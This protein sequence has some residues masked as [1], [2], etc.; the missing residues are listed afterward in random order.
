MHHYT[1]ALVFHYKSN[2]KGHFLGIPAHESGLGL[3][4]SSH[5]EGFL[6]ISPGTAGQRRKFDVRRHERVQDM[7]GCFDT[8]SQAWNSN[9]KSYLTCGSFYQSMA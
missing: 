2:P 3:D 8:P 5:G 1:S 7:R 6:N 9:L 4:G